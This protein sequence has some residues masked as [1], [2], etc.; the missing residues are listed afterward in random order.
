MLNY[1]SHNRKELITFVTLALASVLFL[2]FYFLGWL[3]WLEPISYDWQNKEDRNHWFI[4]ILLIKWEVLVAAVLALLIGTELIVRF[5][6]KYS[7]F[8]VAFVTIATIAVSAIVVYFL[9]VCIGRV[10]PVTSERYPDINDS[11][12]SGHT[13]M[14]T[15]IFFSL[16]LLAYKNNYFVLAFVLCFPP[17]IMGISRIRTGEHFIDDVIAGWLIGVA[18]TFGVHL[19][20]YYFFPNL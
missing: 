9:K 12:P 14:T 2:A 18:C 3:K 8:R 11:F 4:Q 17:I 6:F 1:L 13:L 16:A 7:H 10:R 15:V 19:F 5:G 20:Y